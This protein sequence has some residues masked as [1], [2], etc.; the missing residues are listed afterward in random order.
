MSSSCW[1]IKAT[2]CN[3]SLLRI[4]G[5]N[6][7]IQ[8]QTVKKLIRQPLIILFRY[9]NVCT[10]KDPSVKLLKFADDTTL[11][12]LIQDGDESAYRQEVKELAVWCSLNNLELN[13]L[14]PVE[15]IVDF[16]RN[17]P[18]LPPLTIM[19]STVT[20]VESFR[21]LGTRGGTVHRC[22]SSVRTSVRGSRFDTIS[23][24]HEKKKEI[25]YARFLF[26]Y[27][28]QTVVQIKKNPSRCENTTYYYMLYSQVHKYWD[29]DTILTFLA[30]YTTTM[31]FKWN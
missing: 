1:L 17:R 23:V 8:E 21:F 30:L 6:I 18:A 24:Q 2:S 3:T 9:T 4:S 29:I 14:K 22:H 25:Y 28:E 7:I 5:P 19:N 15:M 12:G 31:D 13:T 16:R 27:F 10:S 11:I 20:A 26:I